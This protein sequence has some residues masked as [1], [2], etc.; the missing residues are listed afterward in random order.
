MTYQ[1]TGVY[2]MT[3]NIAVTYFSN[4]IGM[5]LVTSPIVI[6]M[7]TTTSLAAETMTSFLPWLANLNVK[8]KVTSMF[9]NKI[10]LLNSVYLQVATI[11]D[12]ACH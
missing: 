3:V 9:V 6:N 5:F 8:R 7:P 4:L 12:P 1:K 2:L 10:S 11:L